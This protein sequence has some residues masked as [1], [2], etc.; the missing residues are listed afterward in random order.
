[1]AR[2]AVYGRSGE[3][4]IG[5]SVSLLRAHLILVISFRYRHVRHLS[6]ECCHVVLCWLLLR[7][8]VMVSLLV[9]RDWHAPM[10]VLLLFIARHVPNVLW[11]EPVRAC[12]DCLRSRSEGM[13]AS[14]SKACWCS[15]HDTH[16]DP[17]WICTRVERRQTQKKQ[18]RREKAKWQVR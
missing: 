13:V 18:N 2:Q 17:Q 12:L 8:I 10:I 5:M 15:N 3:I 16:H 6:I 7:L 1:M 11:P 9:R 4:V 14:D